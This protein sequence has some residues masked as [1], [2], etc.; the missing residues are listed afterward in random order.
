MEIKNKFPEY[1]K[2]KK[3]LDVGSLNINGSNNHLFTDCEYIGVDLGAGRNVNV[4]SMIHEYEPGFEFDTIISTNAFEHDMFLDL[5]LKQIVKLLK[6]KGFFIFS[7]AGEGN[8]EHGTIAHHFND[9]PF[10]TK[11]DEW[12]DYYKNVTEE[13]IRESIDVDEIFSEY[14]F[15]YKP[16]DLRFWGVK[17]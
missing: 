4:V 8:Q 10:T 14:E 1:F 13:M 17:K 5:S 16:T 7:C 2:N 15:S 9:S 11:I 6:S 3:V 12:K